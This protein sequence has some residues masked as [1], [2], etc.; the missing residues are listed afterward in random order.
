M[1]VQ[2]PLDAP[3]QLGIVAEWGIVA[4]RPVYLANFPKYLTSSFNLCACADR[5]LK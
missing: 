3:A 5:Y 4:K 1:V 2:V